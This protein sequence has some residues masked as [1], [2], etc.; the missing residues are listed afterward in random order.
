MING[1]FILEFVDVTLLPVPLDHAG[2]QGVTLRLTPGELALIKTES[3]NEQLPLADLAEGLLAP[4]R[5]VVRFL[6]ESW[7]AISPEQSL[8]LRAGIT[9]VFD[10]HGWISNLNVNENVTLAQRHHTRRPI[11]TIMD[12]AETLARS[13][14]L[15]ALPA[16]RP[17]QLPRRDLRRCEWIRAFLGRPQLVLL[18]RPM[19]GVP[20]EFLPRLIGAAKETVARGAALIWLTDEDQVWQNPDLWD[21]TRYTMRGQTLTTVKAT[22]RTGN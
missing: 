5:G 20:L 15:E 16:A 17:A 3:G 7:S 1:N 8:I 21:A 10:E 22:V 4:D 2:L 18:E 13:F 6:G 12:E 19:K 9:R 11:R 14:N